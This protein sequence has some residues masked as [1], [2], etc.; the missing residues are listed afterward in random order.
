MRRVALVVLVLAACAGVA[1]GQPADWSVTRDPF[2]PGVIARL[3]A[4]L[5]RAPYDR[6]LT[7]LVAL[8]RRSRSV[9]QLADEYAHE[10]AT[11]PALVVRARIAAAQGDGPAALAHLRAA[12][13]MNDADIDGWLAIGDAS[14]GEDARHAYEHAL[15]AHPTGALLRTTLRK[16]IELPRDE[17]APLVRDGYYAQLVALDPKNGMLWLE[18]ADALALRAHASLALDAYAHAEALLK[19]DPEHRLYTIVQRGAMHEVLHDPD[20][21]LAEYARAIAA[22]PKG[23]Y[24]RR[25][26]T[27]RTIRIHRERGGLAALLRAYEHDWPERTRGAF[28]WATLGELYLSTENLDGAIRAL[29]HATAKDPTDLAVQRRLIKLLDTAG[30]SADA[31]AQLEAAARAMPKDAPIQFELVQRY[32]GDKPDKILAVLD[33]L[34]KNQASNAAVREEIG[35]L[36]MKLQR[37]D[38]A[39]R[40]YEALVK[41]EP[42]DTTN[43]QKLGDAYFGEGKLAKAVAAWQHLARDRTA[44]AFTTFANVLYDHELYAE[45]IEAY[46]DAIERDRENPELWRARGAVLE[47]TAGWEGA[48]SDTEHAVELYGS[49]PYAKA[50]AAR[51]QLVR[52]LAAMASYE[53]GEL[54]FDPLQKRL[55]AWQTA[56]DT[57]HD[58]AA[59][60]LLAE[61]HSREPGRPLVLIL[62]QLHK[63]VPADEDVTLA[64]VGAYRVIRHYDAA[65]RV[66]AELRH[67]APAR[68][69]ELD[70]LVGQIEKDKVREPQEIDWQDN[71]P[72]D[73]EDEVRIAHLRAQAHVRDAVDDADLV[74][75]GLRL[76]MG[77][78]LRGAA[79]STLTAGG[80]ATLG[81][82]PVH[83]VG[84]VDLSQREGD[85]RSV[86]AVA[87][88]AGVARRIA[89][90]SN[91]ALVISGGY[92]VEHR[93]GA[94]TGAWDKTGFAVDATCDLVL[95]KYPTAIG[96]RLEQ[97][98]SEHARDSALLFEMTFEVR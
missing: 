26:L 67:S 94:M 7:S 34:A 5:T 63:R 81:R 80:I 41:L 65:L 3:K 36:Y 10:P 51:Y 52:V 56:F 12:V 30:R 6:A 68:R 54:F 61:F 50:H 23:Y 44:K 31:L 60:Y 90:T 70:T 77:T 43:I 72:H 58:V 38:L 1:S 87:V 69:K 27:A 55:E 8:Y 57:E 40:E 15:A 79:S 48:L 84:R 88:G 20:A 16:L 4:I 75:A 49:A 86:S 39:T 22:A 71:L 29:Q 53:V 76:G 74:R 78:G 17:L 19:S 47:A 46:S 9:A 25:E 92:R 96:A 32:W 35:E 24:L 97:G 33:R 2:D 89:T 59:G 66:V 83:F 21:A 82:G 73:P 95:R 93:F 37:V 64:L 62:E 11:W 42:D 45:A 14:T 91:L 18:R 28:E 85:M 13:R 98:I